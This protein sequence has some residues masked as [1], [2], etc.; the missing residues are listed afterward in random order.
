MDLSGALQTGLVTPV[1]NYFISDVTPTSD[2]LVALLKNLD[3][4]FGNLG[5]LVD[6]GS[7]DGGLS[8][9]GDAITFTLGYDT[10]RSVSTKVGLGPKGNSLGITFDA[11]ATAALTFSLDFTFGVDLTPGL[12]P[13]DAWFIQVAALVRDGQRHRLADSRAASTWAFLMRRLPAAR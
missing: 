6:D 7:V 8:M 3:G 5:V 12:D 11:T 10:S 1:H 13:Q 9:A 4:S 2:E